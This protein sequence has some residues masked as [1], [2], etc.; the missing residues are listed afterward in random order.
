MKWIKTRLDYLNEAKIRDRINQKQIKAIEDNWGSKYL[1]YEEVDGNP[2]IKQGKW[3]LSN[4]DKYDVLNV[5]CDTNI[6]NLFDL[7]SGLPKKFSEVLSSSIDLSILDKDE[8]RIFQKFDINSPTLDQMILIFN[9]IFRKLSVVDT[10]SNSVILKNDSGVPVRDSEG[11]MMKT[12]KN[13]GDLEFTKN[14][15]NIS[16]FIT[17]YNSLVDKA[18]DKKLSGW[19]SSDKMDIDISRDNNLNKLISY[20]KDGSGNGYKVDIEIFNRDIFLSIS[21]NP[22]DI[23]NMSIS[24]FYTSC[25]HLYSGGFA[26]KVLSNV[27]DP[28]SIPAFLVFETPILWDGEK[29][30]EHLPLSRMIIRSIEKFNENSET[31]LFFDRAYPDRMQKILSNIIEKYSGNI[32]NFSGGTYIYSPDIDDNDNL[33]QP[34]QDRLGIQQV[35]YIGRNIKTLYLSS[36]HDWSIVKID[37]NSRLKELVVETTDVPS[38]LTDINLNLDW[39]KF[40]S[41]D[42]ISLS[43]FNKIKYDAIAFDKC[44][45][46]NEV[47]S[48]IFKS[49]NQI[50]K[51]KI[52]SCDNITDLDFSVFSNLEE[53]HMIYTVNSFDDINIEGLKLKKLVISGDI[54]NKESKIRIN[55]IKQSGTKVEIIGPVI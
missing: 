9:N 52:V 18:I 28:N 12:E 42:I 31:E 14:K 8:A 36:I 38:N 51:L 19:L 46:G 17:D 35:K 2:K 23:L 37:P 1:E 22:A 27:F 34:Y 30:S 21:H 41:I 49:N 11:N 53:L 33:S 13:I 43:S 44:K 15:I 5:F 39:I 54:V 26:E 40:K 20:Y 6:K 7:F 16:T 25:Q 24:K 4:E 50:K 29:I 45:F 48:D 10:M 3:K 47:L 55:K 32:N